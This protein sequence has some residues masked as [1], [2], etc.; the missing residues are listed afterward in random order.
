MGVT[1]VDPSRAERLDLLESVLADDSSDFP[2]V[3]LSG[4]RGIVIGYRA[5]ACLLWEE[6]GE[7]TRYLP[8]A[9]VSLAMRAWDLLTANDLTELN[10]LDWLSTGAYDE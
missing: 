7:I 5:D 10:S 3:F 6:A 9:D 4:S 2:E 8:D 1:L